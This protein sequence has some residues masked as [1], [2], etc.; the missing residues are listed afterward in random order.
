MKKALV[1][2]RPGQDEMVLV[3]DIRIE[4]VYQFQILGWVV[5]REPQRNKHG[6]PV[7]TKAQY[8]RYAE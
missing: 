2:K 6:I 4:Q 1:F 3:G 7:T 5:V 8:L